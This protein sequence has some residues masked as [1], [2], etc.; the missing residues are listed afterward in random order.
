MKHQKTMLAGTF[1]LFFTLGLFFLLPDSTIC[2]PLNSKYTSF[3]TNNLTD[4]E[5]NNISNEI[6][7][8][9]SADN[10]NQVDIDYY[11]Y[12]FNRIPY[13]AKKNEKK[14]GKTKEK[15]KQPEGKKKRQNNA[16]EYVKPGKSLLV[17]PQLSLSSILSSIVSILSISLVISFN[18]FNMVK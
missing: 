16:C 15:K 13:K 8:H 3:K 1:T 17:I 5:F 9:R 12:S 4:N 6:D 11:L 18:G 2:N 14:T 7:N 10:N